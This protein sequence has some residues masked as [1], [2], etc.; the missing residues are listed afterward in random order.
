LEA[1]G[2]IRL[3]VVVVAVVLI[4]AVARVRP[5]H[6]PVALNIKGNLEGPGIFLFTSETCDS[7]EAARAIYRDVLGADGFTEISWDTE[8]ALLTR[9]GVEEIPVGTVLDGSHSEIASFRLVPSRRA[10]ARA[11]RQARR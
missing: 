11:G 1:D 5:E 7:C 10:L 6:K 2:I 8:P 3:V 4:V 9:L